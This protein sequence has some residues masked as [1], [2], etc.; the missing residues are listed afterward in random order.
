VCRRGWSLKCGVRCIRGQQELDR[1]QQELDRG[2]QELDRGQQ[3]LDCGQHEMH[4]R[5][6]AKFRISYFEI[7]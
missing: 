5:V 2:Q 7:G 1:G 4:P 3:E 6:L